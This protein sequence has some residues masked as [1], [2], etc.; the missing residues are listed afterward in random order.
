[1]ITSHGSKQVYSNRWMTVREDQVRFP[2]GDKGVF[3]VVEKPD[4]VA[5]LAVDT[6]SRIHLVQQYRYPIGQRSWEIPMGMWE[7]QPD[8]ALETVAL[9]E[10]KEETGFTPGKITKIGHFFQAPG[11]SSQGCHLFL[12]TGLRAGA[13]EREATES[14]MISAGFSPPQLRQMIANG[15]IK[16]ATTIAAFGYLML[17]AEWSAMFAP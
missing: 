15:E 8:A 2:N 1:M 4:F 16:D 13:T 12:A 17:S 11:Y 7:D 5:I 9:G 10:L 6:E 3:G 14:D